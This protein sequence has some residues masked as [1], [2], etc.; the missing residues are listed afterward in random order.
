MQKNNKESKANSTQN[1]SRFPVT[2]SDS[3]TESL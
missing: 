3:Q 1:Y 2:N